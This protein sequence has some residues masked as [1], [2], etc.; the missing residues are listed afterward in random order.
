M[1]PFNSPYL[2]WW[3]LAQQAWVKS[4]FDPYHTL[5]Q[6]YRLEKLGFVDVEHTHTRWPMG[7]WGDTERERQIGKLH[8][9]TFK[10]F[11]RTAGVPILM[12]NGFMEKDEAERYTNEA[13]EDIEKNHMDRKHYLNV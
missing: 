1:T 13:L 3:N 4:G 8:L 2:R 9:E 12:S 10:V 7:P 11:I 5:R 6:E